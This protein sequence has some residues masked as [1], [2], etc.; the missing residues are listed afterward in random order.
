MAMY[1]VIACAA[2]PEINRRPEG[3]DHVPGMEML[4]MGHSRTELTFSRILRNVLWDAVS[5]QEERVLHSKLVRRKQK[6]VSIRS[7]WVRVQGKRMN[8]A[9]MVG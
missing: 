1:D 7:S 3:E 9:R 4:F 5:K 2:S 8:R 6:G